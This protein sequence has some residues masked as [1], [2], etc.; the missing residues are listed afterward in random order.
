M[1]DPADDEKFIE[2]LYRQ[3]PDEP[4]RPADP[5]YVDPREHAEAFGPDVVREL[6]RSVALSADGSVFFLSGTRGSGKSTQLLR[7][8]EELFGRGYLALRIDAEEFLNV[9]IP[10]NP[11][12]V[13]F[14]IVG[15]VTEA[16]RGESWLPDPTPARRAW[17][18][19]RAAAEGLR[20]DGALTIG[21]P[22]T[23]SL[24]ARLTRDASF[25][26]DLTRHLRGRA[27]ELA[28]RADEQ[29][30]LLIDDLRPTWQAAV[31]DWKGLV[32]LFDSLDHVR[33][34]DFR[35][36]RR[37]LQVVLDTYTQALRLSSC[38]V[39]FVV[40]P[41][42]STGGT[43]R[44]MT[45]VKVATPEGRPFDPG[46]DTLA[47]TVLRRVPGGDVNRLFGDPT[48]LRALAADSGGHLRDLLRL[49]RDAAV[50]SDGLP[51]SRH[52]LDRART[53]TR[54]GM[55]PIAEDELRALRHVR[56]THDVHL[57]EQ[58][59]WE[60]L[61]GLFDRHLILG[62]HNGQDWYDVHPLV[63]TMLTH[64]V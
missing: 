29:L 17:G 50:A 30:G 43:R 62:Y 45:N 36:V 49:V 9:R 63:R 23:A 51:L 59:G 60:A 11:I 19:F 2:D 5:R 6:T 41:W 40:P 16:L 56:E 25:V 52:A 1:P 32:I 53:V 8:Q 34:V 31:A 26:Q 24:T 55:T 10:L 12:E 14:A 38:R 15:G 35:E 27:P 54:Q 13:I 61:A 18:A 7:L 37:Q 21:I 39:L 28:A 57:P 22:P 48:D 42:V 47:E 33:G 64:V 20:L 4:L 3:L 58:E 46:L 44:L